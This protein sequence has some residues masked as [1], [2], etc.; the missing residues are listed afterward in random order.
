VIKQL[1]SEILELHWVPRC[2]KINTQ[3]ECL[4]SAFS[5]LPH[6]GDQAY[7]ILQ[8][9]TGCEYPQTWSDSHTKEEVLAVARL[10]KMRLG[11]RPMEMA[12][13]IE[14]EVVSIA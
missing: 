9:L 10:T 6:Y 2:P 13:E 1:P 14:A 5:I 7:P 8:E 12:V 11:L 4:I 3:E